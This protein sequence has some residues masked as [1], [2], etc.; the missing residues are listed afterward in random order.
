[1]IG[2]WA[3]LL[4]FVF[5]NVWLFYH[6]QRQNFGLMSFIS[7]NLG[8]GRLPAQVNT[9]LNMAA[10]GAIVSLLGTPGFYPNT[11]GIVS[12]E[13]YL[14]T[15]TVGR[16]VYV[17]SLFVMMWVLRSE[18]RLRENAWLSGAIVLGMAFFLPSVLFESSAM[19]FFPYAIAHG[20]QY[21]LMMSVVSGRSSR[22]WQ[23]L[24]GMCA[25]GIGSGLLLE[26]MR[27]WP[28]ILLATG[29]TEVHF[30]VDAKTWRLREPRQRA[31][32]HDR[33]DFLLAA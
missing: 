10:L 29:F 15:R 13:A 8:Y 11:D 32:M 31:I 20:A 24:L 33:F 18:P 9:V 22:G 25:I 3:Y 16:I 1:L 14:V 30:L 26:L 2:P 6:Y 5:H 19:A 27:P 7:T 28:A 23:A 17:V 12:A 21:I 4:I